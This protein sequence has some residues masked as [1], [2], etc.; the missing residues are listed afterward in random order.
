MQMDLQD[1]LVVINEG[2]KKSLNDLTLARSF[3][4][5]QA[6]VESQI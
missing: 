6:L 5:L 3:C 1:S 4:A 2:K